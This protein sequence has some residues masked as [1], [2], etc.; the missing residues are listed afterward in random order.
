MALN[1]DFKD[2]KNGKAF[3]EKLDPNFVKL[4]LKFLSDIKCTYILITSSFRPGTKSSH[5]YGRAV[6]ID[7][8]IIGKEKFKFN[9]WYDST[10]TDKYDSALDEKFFSICK[11]YF[12]E[13]LF[14]YYSPSVIK[15]PRTNS[16]SNKFKNT[17]RYLEWQ[18]NQ[19][20][21]DAINS[22]KPDTRSN[23]QHQQHLNHLHLSVDLQD[24]KMDIGYFGNSKKNPNPENLHKKESS[25]GF[26]TVVAVMLAVSYYLLN[27]KK[28][29]KEE[30]AIA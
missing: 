1:I 14:Q 4:F 16:V 7:H 23:D 17:N 6:D 12:G 11:L 28:E 27:T 2:K 21:L 10:K 25:T 15:H 13:N 18:K 3:F 5:S 24:K 19:K 20:I 29:N 30:V 8:L 9:F 26:L 22:G